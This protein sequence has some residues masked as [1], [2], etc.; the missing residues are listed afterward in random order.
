MSKQSLLKKVTNKFGEESL[1]EI[2]SGLLS[3]TSDDKLSIIKMVVCRHFGY[4]FSELIEGSSR[5]HSLARFI[6]YYITHTNC[7][8]FSMDTIGIKFRVSGRSVHNGVTQIRNALDNPAHYKDI[9]KHLSPI[10]AK[11][12]PM[13]VKVEEASEMISEELTI[14]MIRERTLEVIEDSKKPISFFVNAC[15]ISHS[16]LRDFIEGKSTITLNTL[17]KIQ[18]IAKQPIIE[19]WQRT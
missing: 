16:K 3:S 1:N 10:A 17:L 2:L 7:I 12:E 11:L 19:P 15:G 8:G 4:S 9:I 5:E 6:A 14:K 18:L 13:L